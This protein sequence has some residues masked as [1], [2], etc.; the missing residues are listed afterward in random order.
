MVLT[1][2][3]GANGSRV[4]GNDDAISFSVSNAFQSSNGGSD[5]A[6]IDFERLVKGNVASVASANAMDGAW[7]SP[8]ANSTIQPMRTNSNQ[9]KSG[10]S[11]LT[12]SI[13]AS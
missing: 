4:K 6:E 11:P 13:S 12:G 10:M 9:P 3:S 1:N 5:G 7:D 8:P 2:S